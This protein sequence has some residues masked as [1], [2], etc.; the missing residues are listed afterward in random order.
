DHLYGVKFPDGES[1]DIPAD[2]EAFIETHADRFPGEADGI[3]QFVELAV[4]VTRE[5][6]ALTQRLSLG[7][8]GDAAKRFPT[9]FQYR[10]S[11]VT[12]VLDECVSDPKLKSLL[13][14]SWPYTGTPPS[15]LSFMFHTALLVAELDGGPVYPRGGFQKLADAFVAVL[16]QNDG[17]LL[18]NTRVASI[19]VTDGRATGIV[20]EDGTEIQAPIV[21]SNADATQTFE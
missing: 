20:L 7:E 5:S 21:V 14:A 10:K 18:L 2:Q 4:Q 15:D 8:L 1:F 3:R 11:T 12:D 9:L 16:D 6:Q 13:G 17:E 19:P